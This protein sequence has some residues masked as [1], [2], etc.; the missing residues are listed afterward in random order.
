MIQ[1]CGG[2]RIIVVSEIGPGLLSGRE[3]GSTAG[4]GLS[5]WGVIHSGGVER[6]RVEDVVVENRVV[7]LVKLPFLPVLHMQGIRRLVG[8]K[9][10]ACG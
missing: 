9:L 4:E 2:S 3:Q 8:I 5:S 1:G 6:R 7:F 10:A